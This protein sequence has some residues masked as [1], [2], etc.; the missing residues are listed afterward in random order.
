MEKR[1]YLSGIL[2]NVWDIPVKCTK[3]NISMEADNGILPSRRFQ[4]DWDNP[5]E[6]IKVKD[7]MKVEKGV[8]QR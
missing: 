5:E 1:I 3:V 8:N 6:T 7:Q 4:I 2:H